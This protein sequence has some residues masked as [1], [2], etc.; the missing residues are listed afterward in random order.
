[1]PRVILDTVALPTLFCFSDSLFVGWFQGGP[2]SRPGDAP[3]CLR[4]SA[5]LCIA[6]QCIYLVTAHPRYGQEFS[7]TGHVCHA[8]PTRPARPG[9]QSRRRSHLPASAESAE[10]D[11]S[12]SPACDHRDQYVCHAR[13]GRPKPPR[14]T[15]WN[16][17]SRGCCHGRLHRICSCLSSVRWVGR[18]AAACP[19]ATIEINACVASVPAAKAAAGHALELSL[20]WLLPLVMRSELFV[21]F[22]HS[23]GRQ[24]LVAAACPLATI[25][26]NACVTP[27]PSAEAAAGHTLDPSPLGGGSH[28]RIHRSLPRLPERPVCGC[29]PRPGQSLQT[30]IAATCHDA[31]RPSGCRDQCVCHVRPD[32]PSRRGPRFGT[33]SLV[34]AATG[35][36]IGSVHAFPAFAGSANSHRS[37]LPAC[38]HRDQYVWHTR[39]DSRSRRGSHFGTVAP[40]WQWPR[41]NPSE[42]ASTSGETRVRVHPSAWAES[43]DC[44][45]GNSPRCA[46]TFGLR[47]STRVPCPSGRPKPQRATLWNCR[48]RGCC[49]GRFH[50]RGRF[51][52]KSTSSK[53]AANPSCRPIMQPPCSGCVGA[54]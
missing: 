45:R 48:S 47:R 50:R 19:L 37:G 30:A 13:P 1:M 38:D 24:T 28:G 2:E 21:P 8:R 15:L 41:A 25:K 44:D 40:R 32:G 9:G 27:V 26:I 4:N 18:I 23:L 43:A 51:Q 54:D 29:T 31:L 34:A 22:Q 46:A 12:V 52:R 49:H 10:S 35:D 33:V 7:S 14:V 36:S 20:R 11:R 17:R 16:C 5:H 3:P 53:T 6:R 39:P 42:L